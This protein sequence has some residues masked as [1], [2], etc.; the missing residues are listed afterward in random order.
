M[1]TPNLLWSGAWCSRASRTLVGWSSILPGASAQRPAGSVGAVVAGRLPAAT[2]V[3][4]A[5]ACY[6]SRWLHV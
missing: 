2:E 4:V 6:R 3:A 5:Q 1:K